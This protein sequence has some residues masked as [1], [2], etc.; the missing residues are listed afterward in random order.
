MTETIIAS[1]V[2]REDPR[3]GHRWWRITDATGLRYST[4]NQWHAALCHEAMRRHLSVRLWSRAGWYYRDLDDV[5]LV[6]RG[7]A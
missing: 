5:R 4:T 2:E 6:E 3:T 1:V 7:V